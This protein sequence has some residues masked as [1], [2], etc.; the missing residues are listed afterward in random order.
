VL[1]S[2]IGVE[3]EGLA[4]LKPQPAAPA[5]AW[6][7]RRGHPVRAERCQTGASEGSAVLWLDSVPHVQRPA[8]QS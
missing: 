1:K 4:R 5:A 6:E 8:R 7:Q 3:D 2:A